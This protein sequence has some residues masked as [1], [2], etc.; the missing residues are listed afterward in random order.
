MGSLLPARGSGIH[1]PNPRFREGAMTTPTKTPQLLHYFHHKVDPQ[2][3][4]GGTTVTM[5]APRELMSL[6]GD[7]VGGFESRPPARFADGETEALKWSWV[8]SWVWP[9]PAGAPQAGAAQT[10]KRKSR[11]CFSSV[12]TYGSRGGW[13]SFI[14]RHTHGTH[15]THTAPG[16]KG[17]RPA[18]PFLQCFNHGS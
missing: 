5:W 1:L 3:A 4:G 7:G 15:T 13:M 12:P 11:S 16:R 14:L 2:I 10:T 17:W 8:P 9:P 6:Q 18:L